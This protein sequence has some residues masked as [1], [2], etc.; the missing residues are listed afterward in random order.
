MLYGACVAARSTVCVSAEAAGNAAGVGVAGSVG[1]GSEAPL[2]GDKWTGRVTL[3]P[4]W[5]TLGLR[6]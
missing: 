6:K 3:S 2:M 4:G 1:V 5:S